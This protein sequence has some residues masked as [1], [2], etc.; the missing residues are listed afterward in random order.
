[1][2][3]AIIWIFGLLLSIILTIVLTD[4]INFLLARLF[5]GSI[6][7]SKGIRG[8]W[9]ATSEVISQGKNRKIIRYFEVKQFGNYIIA[10]SITKSYG[11]YVIR[12]KLTKKMVLSGSWAEITLDSR[13]YSGVIQLILGRHKTEIKGK[14]LS[15]NRNNEVVDG[16]WHWTLETRDRSKDSIEKYANL[17]PKHEPNEIE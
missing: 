3:A 12:G 5:G 4:P 14:Y 13:E 7:S 9:K 8:I 1:M 6:K 16:T 17:N 10:K 15:Y 2:S 11:N